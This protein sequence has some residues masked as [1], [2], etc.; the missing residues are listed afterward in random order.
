MKIKYKDTF[1]YGRKTAKW[2]ILLAVVLSV[3]SYFAFSG[4]PTGQAI[5]VVLSFLMMIAGF[6]VIYNF[7]RCPYCGKKIMLGVL[8]V[9][10]CPKC[11][12]NLKT[13]KKSKK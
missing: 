5:T 7:C 1:E 2:L 12:R 4:N 6:V 8:A 11:R 9:T 13:G 3:I 10:S